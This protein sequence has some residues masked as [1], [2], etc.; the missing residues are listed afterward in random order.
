VEEELFAREA[1]AL[2][3][4]Q[5]DTIVRRRL[6]QKLTF[7]IDDTSRIVEPAE[8][9]LRRFYMTNAERFRTDARVSFSQVFFNP[10]R[11]QHADS[12]AQAA[13]ISISAKGGQADTSSLGDPLLVE[14]EFHDAD[15]QTVSNLFGAEFAEAVFALDPGQW[16][17]PIKSGYGLHL[18][19]V[20][21]VSQGELK[22][23]EEIRTKVL[24][25]WRSQQ[26]REAKVAYLAKLREKYGVIIDDSVKPLLPGADGKAK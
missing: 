2:G 5:N 16:S 11:R 22:P 4:D 18:V 1:L 9:E 23:F 10:E 26:E 6:A 13:L 12:D 3:L 20:S 25:E 14:S 17:G 21:D 15:R 19:R 24:E 7:L 8:D